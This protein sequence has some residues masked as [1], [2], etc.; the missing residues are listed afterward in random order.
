M[1][2]G[3]WEQAVPVCIKAA[4]DAE[5]RLAYQE[6]AALYERVLPHVT[7][8][9]LRTSLTCRWGNALYLAGDRQRAAA[10]L[11]D[12]VRLPGEANSPEE[13]APYTLRL[14]GSYWDCSHHDS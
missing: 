6:A 12:G 4:E 2:A 14:A 10:A 5:R 1:E 8:S 13:A 9:P 11:E 7:G 3:H